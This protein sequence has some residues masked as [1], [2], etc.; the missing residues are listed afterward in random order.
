MACLMTGRAYI[1][2]HIQHKEYISG[3]LSKVAIPRQQLCETPIETAEVRVVCVTL[4]SRAK[5]AT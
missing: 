1:L 4:V 2:Q 5:H 3:A